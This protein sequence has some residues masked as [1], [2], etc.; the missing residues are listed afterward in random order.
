MSWLSICTRAC[1]G[2]N[3]ILGVIHYLIFFFTGNIVRSLVLL[4][5]C[6]KSIWDKEWISL[7]NIF[8]TRRKQSLILFQG[9]FLKKL[10][11]W[12]RWYIDG[13]F[14][15][16]YGCHLHSFTD[17]FM[18]QI[19]TKGKYGMHK[20]YKLVNAMLPKGQV[21]RDR[22]SFSSPLSHVFSR[23]TFIT[24]TRHA[25]YWKTRRIL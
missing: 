22:F 3:F 14:C 8:W 17:K 12:R 1:S 20:V 11:F 2:L 13:F 7:W 25:F 21:T 24:H 4:P 9:Y 5:C 6:F 15:Y 19:I 16:R 23:F 18:I 10:S